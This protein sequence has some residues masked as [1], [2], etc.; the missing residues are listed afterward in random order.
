MY[1]L[2]VHNL[3]VHRLW[4]VCYSLLVAGG[5]FILFEHLFHFLF[6]CLRL[7]F[8]PLLVFDELKIS[9]GFGEHHTPVR[10]LSVKIGLPYQ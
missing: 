2:V 3:N 4:L 9:I 10:P 1:A 6:I 8:S 5:I 7:C